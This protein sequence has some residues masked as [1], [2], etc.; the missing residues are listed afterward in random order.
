MWEP[1]TS[2]SI[3][4]LLAECDQIDSTHVVLIPVSIHALL[5]ECDSASSVEI[6]DQ[7]GFNP[8]TPCGVRLLVF[9]RVPGAHQFQSTHS[10]R[11]ATRGERREKRPD[12]VSIHAL[13]AEC[14]RSQG[15]RQH[16][17]DVS[18]HALLAECDL[19]T[20]NIQNVPINVSIHALLAECDPE[21][22]PPRTAGTGFNPRTPCG[23]RL[24]V[25]R[26]WPVGQQVSIHALL[27]EC[28]CPCCSR[29]ST[30]RRFNP[31]TPCG[32]RLPRTGKAAG[33]VWFQ[34]THSLRSATNHASSATRFNAF[35]STHSLRSAT[36]LRKLYAASNMFQSTHSLRS[37]TRPSG[38]IGHPQSVSI[39]ALLAECDPLCRTGPEPH[40]VSIHA[41]L[42]ECDGSAGIPVFR[43]QRV[44]IH[45]LLAECD[46]LVLHRKRL[47]NS[48][49]P[50][51]PCGV[52][53]WRRC[54]GTILQKFQS[55]HSL[56]S[57]THGPRPTRR[58]FPVSIHA[59]LAECDIKNNAKLFSSKGFNPRTPCGVRLMDERSRAT[60]FEFQSTH[61][62]RSATG[63]PPGDGFIQPVSIHALLAECDRG[64]PT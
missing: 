47:C 18:I 36:M 8:R 45:A 59:L 25:R 9:C 29:L 39:H 64:F 33:T 58:R 3:H 13:L 7:A 50:R 15:R 19:P 28:D 49:N 10:L 26:Q 2:V 53:H 14:D 51:T 35:Q 63:R 57:A 17:K 54:A 16:Q 61:S 42:A 1:R 52:R 55:T 22:C 4:A 40:A 37:A 11:S 41:L 43:P 23:V 48:F 5:A 62:L 21:K 34:S 27:A 6:V 31:R 12:E 56:R 20:C 60:G 30:T 32:V 24:H 44:S 46:H 38:R